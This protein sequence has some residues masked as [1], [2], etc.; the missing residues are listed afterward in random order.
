M[1]TQ[2]LGIYEYKDRF[3]DEKQKK[4]PS[5]MQLPNSTYEALLLRLLLGQ[6]D[7]RKEGEKTYIELMNNY[8]RLPYQ[9]RKTPTY[10]S[11]NRVFRTGG[12]PI[13]IT[14]KHSQQLINMYFSKNRNNVEIHKKVLFELSCCFINQDKAPITV[15]AHLYRCLEYMSYSFPMIYASKSR[16]YRGTFDDLKSFLSGK[17]DSELKFF[18]QFILV[19]FQDEFYTLRYTFDITLTLNYPITNLLSDC[20]KIYKK[21]LF[22][23][24]PENKIIHVPFCN[25]LDFFVTTRNR[26]FHMQIGKGMN[27][28][29]TTEYDI[30]EY[31]LSINPYF[32]NWL[33]LIIQ[34]IIS[35]G[36]YTLTN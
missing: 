6:I 14:S 4:L 22:I 10:N 15:F 34:K 35:Y 26:Y 1:Q 7:I 12:N 36:V 13:D 33:A 17:D 11:I 2:S 16:N 9:K 31:F 23:S 19:L 27:N 32:L 30:N 3:L 24:E 5:L 25:M 8:C 28:F 29:E 20:E 21:D 18:K